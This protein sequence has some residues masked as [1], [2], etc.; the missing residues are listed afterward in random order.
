MKEWHVLFTMVPLN[1]LYDQDIHVFNFKN[2]FS[3]V[4]LKVTCKGIDSVFV[5]PIFLQPYDVNLKYFKL[6]LLDL[7]AFIVW[8]IKGLR[9]WVATIL[10]LEN[11]S[12]WQKLNSFAQEK[13]WIKLLIKYVSYKTYNIF[14]VI[15]YRLKGYSCEYG[16]G[17]GMN[18]WM[19]N[20][21]DD[22]YDT[23]RFSRPQLS[24]VR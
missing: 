19:N 11:Q 21:V 5:K 8:N 12:L 13:L 10:N 23:R 3:N 16:I 18:K 4:L 9:H 2:I 24:F 20:W 22:D 1:A 14:H 17:R 15:R 7:I 6:T